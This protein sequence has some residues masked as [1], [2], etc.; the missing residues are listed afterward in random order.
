[1]ADEQFI[2]YTIVEKKRDADG[3]FTVVLRNIG[4]YE[5]LAEARAARDAFLDENMNPSGY[6]AKQD[7]GWIRYGEPVNDELHYYIEPIR[8]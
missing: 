4:A 5:T 6:D 1:M 7:Y 3:N 2:A 8:P